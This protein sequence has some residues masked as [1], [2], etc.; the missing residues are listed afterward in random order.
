MYDLIRQVKGS[1]LFPL[2]AV[3][4]FILFFIDVSSAQTITSIS[5]DTYKGFRMLWGGG[6][7][8]CWA[9]ISLSGRNKQNVT[10]I[11]HSNSNR[12]CLFCNETGENCHEYR[13]DPP[14]ILNVYNRTHG[15]DF[16]LNIRDGGT[17][18][19]V[20][21]PDNFIRRFARAFFGEESLIIGAE[22]QYNATITNVSLF[23]SDANGIQGYATLNISQTAPYNSL[24]LYV[25]Y[26]RNYTGD[27]GA[28]FNEY[29]LSTRYL[30]GITKNFTEP[31]FANYIASPFG[32]AYNYSA[33][34]GGGRQYTDLGNTAHLSH[35]GGNFTVLMWIRPNYDPL[36]LT[37]KTLIRSGVTTSTA[38][39]LSNYWFSVRTPA[40]SQ[41]DL[42]VGNGLSSLEVASPINTIVNN[43][44][45]QV[46]FRINATNNIMLFRNGVNVTAGT[47]KTITGYY[48]ADNTTRIG[49][50]TPTLNA[51]GWAGMIDEVMIFNTSLTD[52]QILDIYNNNS[53]RFVTRGIMEFKNVNLSN[54]NTIVVY[55]DTKTDL[56][57]GINIS[58]NGGP[59]VPMVGDTASYSVTGEL[60]NANLSFI[61]YTGNK[62]SQFYSPLIY[63]NITVESSYIPPPLQNFTGALC[64]GWLESP[65]RI[66]L[67]SNVT[68]CSQQLY[69]F[70]RIVLGRNQ[71]C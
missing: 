26:D 20:F 59:E 68:C 48:G 9:D 38:F 55:A 71:T 32:Y 43:E 69:T 35:K 56:G 12:I 53:A 34:T 36:D 61:L 64:V 45:Q 65:K 28:Q 13:V 60:Q 17:R 49:A 67:V 66:R 50:V 29:D 40:S 46:G 25:N 10:I 22:T 24:I 19:N 47:Q 6:N 41:L 2:L 58:V 27:V 42:V 5:P 8:S 37:V 15:R 14:L 4:T 31:M 62:T 11:V 54:N 70:P 63:G 33:G 16:Q 51:R 7:E 52:Q 39:Q 18:F 23:S 57:S 3:F 1:H 30:T 44:W 21:V